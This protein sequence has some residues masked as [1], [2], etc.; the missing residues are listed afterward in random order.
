MEDKTLKNLQR[1]LEYI[2]Y[3]STTFGLRLLKPFVATSYSINKN[4][5]RVV[6]SSNLN[7]CYFVE[8]SDFDKFLSGKLSNSVSLKTGNAFVDNGITGFYISLEENKIESEEEGLKFLYGLRFKMNDIFYKIQDV[9]FIKLEM[10]NGDVFIDD[11]VKIYVVE[12]FGVEDYLEIN[13]FVDTAK[14]V[15]KGMG[16]SIEIDGDEV[17]EYV[18]L[19][20]AKT[21]IKM[22]KEKSYK[23]IN[24]KLRQVFPLENNVSRKVKAILEQIL[25]DDL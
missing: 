21:A 12:D 15:K 18:L 8:I 2:R 17:D 11:K 13:K 22:S 25:I 3:N 14:Y 19:S 24:E 6:L 10:P 16:Y 20:D 23:Q 9:A 1:Y 4:K 5:Y 7:D